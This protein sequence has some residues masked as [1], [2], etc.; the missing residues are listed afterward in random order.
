MK[1]ISYGAFYGC[2]SLTSIT[3]PIN[4]TNI[5]KYVFSYCNELTSITV[6]EGNDVYDSRN[7][8]NGIIETATNTLIA[9]CQNTVMPNSVTCIGQGAFCG[10]NSIF[11]VTIPENVTSIGSEAFYNCNNLTSV[12]IPEGVTSIGSHTFGYCTSLKEIYCYAEET[13]EIN[14]SAF[15]GVTVS[16]ILLVVPDNAVEKYRAHPVW[17]QFMIETQTD[18]QTPTLSPRRGEIYNISGLRLDKMPKGIN[19]IRRSD[20]T[21]RKVMVK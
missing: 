3:I 18:I 17:G 14:E 7:D 21:T 15:N 16:E 13:P 11:S 9:G 6:E 12:S 2:R 8:C 20:G 10:C 19:I 5:E 1:H 4:V